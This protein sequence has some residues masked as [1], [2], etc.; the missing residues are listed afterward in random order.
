MAGKRNIIP[1]ETKLKYAKL[2][3]EKKMSKKAASRELG[4]SKSEILAWVYRYQ[5][6]GELAF[7]NT[8][9]NKVYPEQ[10]RQE[11]VQSYLNGEGSFRAVAAR[12][13]LRSEGPLKQWVKMYNGGRNLLHKKSGECHMKTAKEITLDERIQIVKECL[14]SGLRYGEIAKK[15]GISYQLLYVWVQRYTELGEAGL[16]DRRGKRKIDQMPRNER[17]KLQIE[18]KQ[19]KQQLHT[20]EMERDLLKKVSELQRKDRYRK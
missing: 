11:A 19:L 20:A 15:H 4:V 16:E 9:E 13:G 17:E 6:Q 5:E 7:L 3:F 18:I 1:D 14:E 10:V 2:C 8:N 12:Y